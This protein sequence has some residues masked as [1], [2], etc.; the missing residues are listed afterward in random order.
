MR[1]PR[2]RFTVRR[3]L[4]AVA[5]IAILLAVTGPLLRRRDYCLRMAA[6]HAEA[7]ARARAAMRSQR[8]AIGA[9]PRHAELRSKYQRVAAR[10]W[11]SLPDDPFLP[12]PPRGG[13]LPVADK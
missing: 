2:V 1:F 12:D 7:E 8:S 3:V 13:S 5:W 10:P 9:A 4:V 6:R 11:E